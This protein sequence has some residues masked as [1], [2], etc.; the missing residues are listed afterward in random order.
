MLTLFIGYGLILVII[1]VLIVLGY[2]LNN[3]KKE[4]EKEVE[5]VKTDSLENTSVLQKRIGYLYDLQKNARVKTKK[6]YDMLSALE[7]QSNDNESELIN[8]NKSLANLTADVDKNL[9]SVTDLNKTFTTLDER[10]HNNS[11]KINT[12]LSNFTNVNKSL[13][14]LTADVDKTFTTLDEKIIENSGK[15]NKNS[16]ENIRINKS[17]NG[18][19]TDLDNEMT[20]T[21]AKIDD[22]ND[23]LTNFDERLTNKS[24]LPFDFKKLNADVL[25]LKQLQQFVEAKRVQENTDKIDELMRISANVKEGDIGDEKMFTDEESD[26]WLKRI[27]DETEAS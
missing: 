14:N 25:Q 13:A 27:E 7:E 12:N 19:T 15:I 26:V 23:V 8:V 20:K 3:I 11:D 2:Q 9:T 24:P 10:V 6:I 22:L 18:L 5:K 4:L 16:T 17:L 21:S 1:I